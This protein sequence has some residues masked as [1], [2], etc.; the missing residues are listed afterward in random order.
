[1]D[2]DRIVRE[3]ERVE[4]TGYAATRW[5]EMEREGLAPR[6]RQIGPRA[7]GWLLSELMAWVTS[8]PPVAGRAILR[9]RE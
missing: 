2:V 1:M 9:T 8:R 7:V 5:R 3:R 4:I 6:R